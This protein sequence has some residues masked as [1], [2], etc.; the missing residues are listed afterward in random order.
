MAL[1][2]GSRIPEKLEA[3]MDLLAITV[4]R[5]LAE[6]VLRTEVVVYT[7]AKLEKAPERRTSASRYRTPE[8]QR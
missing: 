4:L 7:V 5:G 8:T 6:S 2:F 3:K 1:R